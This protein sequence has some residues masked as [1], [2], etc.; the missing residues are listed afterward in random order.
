MPAARFF[1]AAI[2][3]GIY[4]AMMIPANAEHTVAPSERPMC[5]ILVHET[6]TRPGR[7][8][9]REPSDKTVDAWVQKMTHMQPEK[10]IL[11]SLS[12]AWRWPALWAR[13]RLGLYRSTR[14][15]VKGAYMR[16]HR[17]ELETAQRL[18]KITRQAAEK[19]IRK[20]HPEKLKG[21][22]DLENAFQKM[23][24]NGGCCRVVGAAEAWGPG[25][26][27]PIFGL[28]EAPQPKSMPV[29]R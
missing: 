10:K 19:A 2:R 26:Q 17:A 5:L 21:R 18:K 27:G 3:G 25:V 14:L 15:Q 12:L 20:W 8:E 4:K 16:R 28:P 1:L 6:I 29:R 11:H 24:E 9:Q 22:K 7:V 13:V 23:I